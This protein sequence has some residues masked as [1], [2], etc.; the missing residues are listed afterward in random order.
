MY[1]SFIFQ[2]GVTSLM[3]ASRFGHIEVCELLLGHGVDIDIADYVW[4]IYD[5]LIIRL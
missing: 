2:N 3:E 1:I 5:M 4:D